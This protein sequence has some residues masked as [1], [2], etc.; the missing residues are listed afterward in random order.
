MKKLID[1]LRELTVSMNDDEA[2][3]VVDEFIK[4][5]PELLELHDIE[6]YYKYC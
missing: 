4:K 1:E 5:H 6:W 2:K 3:I